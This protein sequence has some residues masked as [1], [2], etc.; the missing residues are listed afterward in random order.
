MRTPNNGATMEASALRDVC[1]QA[2]GAQGIFPAECRAFVKEYVPQILHALEILPPDQVS[3]TPA[4]QNP[5]A[6]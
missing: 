2:I 1:M 6:I 4:R 5:C 3:L